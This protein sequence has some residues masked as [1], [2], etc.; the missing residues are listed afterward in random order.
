[1]TALDVRKVL[2]NYLLL[3]KTAFDIENR[4]SQ[5]LVHNI[6]LTN[7]IQQSIFVNIYTQG[8]FLFRG[9]FGIT[10][11]ACCSTLL[12][13]YRINVFPPKPLKNLHRHLT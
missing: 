10:M 13:M 11:T 8:M 4:V 6:K 1:M 7:N 3:K 2:E 9:C 12:S 5:H